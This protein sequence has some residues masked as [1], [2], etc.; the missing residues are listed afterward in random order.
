MSDITSILTNLLKATDAAEGAKK[1]LE[2]LNSVKITADMDP[3][4]IDNILKLRKAITSLNKANEEYNEIQAQKTKLDLETAEGQAELEKLNKQQLETMKKMDAAN[5]VVIGTMKQKSAQQKEVI[6]LHEQERQAIIANWKQNTIQGRTLTALTGTVAKFAAGLTAGTMALKLLNRVQDS[7][8]LRNDLMIA[9][10]GKLDD[11]FLSAVT[12]IGSYEKAVRSAESTAISLGMA[13]EDVTQIMLNY[14]RIVGNSTPEA[15]GA[16]TEATLSMAKVMNITG[17]QA[18]AYV[19]ARMDNF[20][21]SAASALQEL[22]NLRESVSSYNTALGGT[23]LRG[24]DVLKII[25]DITNSSTV[26]AADQRFLSSIIQRSS[27]ILQSQGESY[28]YAQKQAENFSK[29]LSS[30]APEWMQIT[31]AFDIT[32]QVK[33]NTVTGTDGAKR[34][35]E[36]YAL[37]LEKA[38]PGLSSKVTEMLNAGYS[39][40]DLTRLLGDTLKDTEVGLSSMSKKI[41]QLGSGSGGISRLAAVYGKSHLEAME[42]YKQAVKVNQV[43]ELKG[44]LESKSVMVSTTG[45]KQMQETLKLTDEQVAKAREN[46]FYRDAIVEQYS[47]EITKQKASASIEQRKLEAKAKILDYQSKIALAEDMLAQ[48][49]KDGDEAMIGAAKKQI[50]DLK[51]MESQARKDATGDGTGSKSILGALTEKVSAFQKATGLLTGDYFKGFLNDMASPTVLALGGIAA[52]LWKGFGMT[53]R[54]EA[55]L[56]AI[57]ENTAGGGRGGRGGSGGG[58]DTFGK[59][60]RR[61]RATRARK[62]AN[63]KKYGKGVGGLLRRGKDLVGRSVSKGLSA[64]NLK[65]MFSMN[66][67]K[68]AGKLV[69]GAGAIGGLLGAL[70]FGTSAGQAYETGGVKG[71]VGQ[72]LKSFGGL[73]GGALGLLGGP[74]GSVLG[75]MA[76][77]YLGGMAGDYLLQSGQDDKLGVNQEQ[78]MEA[79]RK[80]E[81]KVAPTP[82][83]GLGTQQAQNGAAGVSST[84]QANK[85]LDPNG[86]VT[87]TLPFMDWMAQGVQKG[88]NG[89]SGFF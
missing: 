20:G 35:T 25:Q 26:Y 82:L 48:A 28:N 86:N 52:I 47:E 10:Y 42:M 68:G 15:L 29:A 85:N 53:T 16:L 62:A 8:K 30:E 69:K 89:P 34:L 84:G 50:A 49:E 88:T 75:G 83:P 60:K 18:M 40:Y 2:D 7:A 66:T 21:G 33:Q 77:D 22:D 14:Q 17:S 64:K 23:K 59:N 19:Q 45:Y 6:R 3:K 79:K 56:E 13:N 39:E 71:V 44:K 63:V 81:P 4:T 73:A 76:G 12:S 70:D 9:S 37:Q 38:K 80:L 11:N 54:M 27:V 36:A 24:D 67:L 5:G 41:E 74:V 51:A 1:A 58:D 32:K 87:V 31:N 72:G 55:W 57:A 61:D 43:T 78:L 65:S 46:S